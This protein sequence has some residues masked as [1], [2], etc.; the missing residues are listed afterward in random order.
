M[1]GS[2]GMTLNLEQYLFAGKK[3]RSHVSLSC[4]SN[5]LVVLHM[6]FEIKHFGMHNAVSVAGG[7]AASP[8]WNSS[9]G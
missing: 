6:E 3:K 8:S 9:P 2:F 7:V 4:F 1:A 5:S